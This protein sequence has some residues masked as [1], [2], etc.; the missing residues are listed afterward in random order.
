MLRA[1]IFDFN[2]VIADDETPHVH[3]FC[4][5]LK[6]FGLRLTT[7]E[8][9]GTYLGMDERTC[10]AL[11]LTARDG[12]SDERLLRQIQE[13]KAE[14]FRRYTAAH[15]P[16]LFP[17]VVECVKAAK[18]RYRLAIASGGRREQIDRALDRTPIQYD[19]ELI[20]SAEDCPIGKPDPAIYRLAL[21]RLNGVG[22]NLPLVQPQEC[23]VIED[24]L[25][26]IRSAR[27]AGMFVLGLATTYSADHLH[28]ADLVLPSLA[29][30]DPEDLFTRLSS[31]LT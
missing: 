17:G 4:Q 18:P 31:R 15:K 2:G 12:H 16:E 22:T 29:G 14:L 19:F 9:Y 8:Y 23:L 28:E 27:A 21:A 3:C 20:V 1:I 24:S 25:A 13:R 11:L 6:E 10:T 30:V 26:G 5:A 7:E